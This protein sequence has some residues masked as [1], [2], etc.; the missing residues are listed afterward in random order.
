MRPFFR[1][2]AIA[3]FVCCAFFRP[4]SAA[5]N[6]ELVDCLTSEVSSEL[7]TGSA[8]S[9][10]KEYIESPK[11]KLSEHEL[12]M[13]PSGARLKIGVLMRDQKRFLSL[14]GRAMDEGSL[15]EIDAGAVV[16]PK[17]FIMLNHLMWQAP[18]SRADV[19][20]KGTFSDYTIKAAREQHASQ[21]IS[22]TRMS[23]HDAWTQQEVNDFNTAIDELGLSRCHSSRCAF[24]IKIS[25]GRAAIYLTDDG[26]PI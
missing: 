4:Q 24:L 9:K 6:W 2:A 19:I 11:N 14:C 16:G 21:T 22:R 26:K 7:Q 3:L 20:I 18:K 15:H 25:N 12:V 23:D 1:T 8:L 5:A 17:V 10:L 13:T